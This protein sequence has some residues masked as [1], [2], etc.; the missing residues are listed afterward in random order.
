[1]LA[2]GN[3]LALVVSQQ[4]GFS[5]QQF[6]EYHPAGSLG[7][8]LKRVT[9]VMRPLSAIR[10]ALATATVREALTSLACPG[11]RSGAMLVV[12][13]DDRLVGL[14]TDSD[15]ARLLEQRIDD[16]LGQPLASVMTSD[17]LTLPWTA[18]L[19]DLLDLLSNRKVSEVPVVDAEHRP[20]GLTDITDLIGWAPSSGAT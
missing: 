20:L 6:A 2:V 14:F 8:K 1:M 19:A 11:R 16:V 5:P 3:A 9:E 10:V 7:R 15:L 13:E 17:P 4:K 18:T 12:D